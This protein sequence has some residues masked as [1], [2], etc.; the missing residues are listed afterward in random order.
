ML[1]AGLQ[2]VH[3]QTQPGAQT[4]SRHGAIAE[5]RFK[6]HKD[7]FCMFLC[8]LVAQS[9]LYSVISLILYYILFS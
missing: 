4:R 9:Y 7:F 6:D 5:K 2:E 8:C 1:F 3:K